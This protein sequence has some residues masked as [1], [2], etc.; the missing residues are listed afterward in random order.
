M[1][2]N[3]EYHD[4]KWNKIIGIQERFSERLGFWQ[5]TLPFITKELLHDLKR[6][7]DVCRLAM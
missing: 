4:Q 6:A 7:G 5:V 1:Q 3:N 2:F